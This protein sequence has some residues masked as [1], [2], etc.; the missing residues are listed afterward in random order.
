MI[1]LPLLENFIILP[2]LGSNPG[3]SCQSLLDI[4]LLHAVDNNHSSTQARVKTGLGQ[5]M[6]HTFWAKKTE[7]N[8]DIIDL[9]TVWGFTTQENTKSQSR[10]SPS[11][12][13]RDVKITQSRKALR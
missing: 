4:S 2:S 3:S 11:P 6:Y 10:I 9:T 8:D 7:K 5:K 1:G 13:P 12:G